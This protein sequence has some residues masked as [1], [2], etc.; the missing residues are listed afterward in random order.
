MFLKL[1]LAFTLIPIAELY[2]LVKA[3]QY[4]GALNTVVIVIIT[5][6]AGAYLARLQGIHTLYKIKSALQ[7][8]RLPSGE[9][10]DALLIFIAGMALLMPGFITD[11][12]GLILLFP[13]GRAVVKKLL[14]EKIRVWMGSRTIH[15]NYNP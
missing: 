1:F 9:L 3:G 4:I 2:L 5:G 10:V 14:A 11:A 6:V 7:Q 8:G 12:A 15:I 13:P